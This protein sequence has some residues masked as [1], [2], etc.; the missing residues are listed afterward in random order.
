L[1]RSFLSGLAALS[2]QDLQPGSG[3]DA[4]QRRPLQDAQ[5]RL[6]ASCDALRVR[7]PEYDGLNM[8]GKQGRMFG[9]AAV[10]PAIGLMERVKPLKTSVK[11]PLTIIVN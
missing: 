2:I 9:K 4:D 10:I 8:D 6:C 5:G 7:Q 3:S 1:C 11:L